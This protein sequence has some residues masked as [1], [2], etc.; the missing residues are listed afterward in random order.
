M[1]RRFRI[2]PAIG[3]ARVGNAPDDFFVGP[4]HPGIPANM[5]NGLFQSFHDAQGRIKRQ[6]ARFTIFEYQED[7]GRLSNPREV[8]LS[9]DDVVDIEWRG[10]VANPKASFFT[11]N[12]QSGAEAAYGKR[13]G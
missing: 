3:V 13:R 10:H 7:A 4:E 2:H 9:P 12:G 5:A 8:N 1:G 11:F 6:A